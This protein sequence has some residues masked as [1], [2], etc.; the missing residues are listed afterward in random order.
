MQTSY[1]SIGSNIAKKNA[2]FHNRF[3]M[4]PKIRN[5]SLSVSGFPQNQHQGH[6]FG[7]RQ[8]SPS[9]LLN[10]VEIN[11]HDNA[12][13]ALTQPTI[14]AGSISLLAQHARVQ[15]AP[16]VKVNSM[17][18][19]MDLKKRL[20]QNREKSRQALIRVRNKH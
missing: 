8:Q 18:R 9:P 15:K 16:P 13:L 3:Q 11:V 14:L 17:N 4:T 19:L 10:P 5:W 2:T 1:G 6:R 20:I 12:N 7:S